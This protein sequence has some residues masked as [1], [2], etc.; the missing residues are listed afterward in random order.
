MNIWLLSSDAQKTGGPS[1]TSKALLPSGGRHG[2]FETSSTVASDVVDMPGGY[3]DFAAPLY[4]SAPPVPVV[5]IA[6]DHYIPTKSW[7]AINST[8]KVDQYDQY[9]GLD[10]IDDI[11]IVLFHANIPTVGVQRLVLF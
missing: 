9:L 4:Q 11:I 2:E 7:K 3:S 6:N 10:I 1:S 8:E 5:P